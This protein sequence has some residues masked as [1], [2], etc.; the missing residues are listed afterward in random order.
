[1]PQPQDQQRDGKPM[2]KADID[3]RHAER[4][5]KVLLREMTLNDALAE[6]AADW[7]AVGI[8]VDR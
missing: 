8:K 3:R 2:T 7:H 4:Y 1:M 5:R 6:N